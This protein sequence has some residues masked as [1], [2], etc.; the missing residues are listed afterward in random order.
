MEYEHF[1]QAPWQ[2][3][4][5]PN[6]KAVELACPHCGEYYHDEW[7]LDGFQYLRRNL[8]QPVQINSARRCA[9]YNASNKIGGAVHSQHK[10]RVAFDISIRNRD[11]AKIL[12]LLREYGYSTFGF[13]GSFIHVDARKNRKWSTKSGKKVWKSLVAF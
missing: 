9:F 6:F 5:W 7:M 11:P 12:G 3:D 1:S 2:E 4:R 8:N 13:Y 10:M